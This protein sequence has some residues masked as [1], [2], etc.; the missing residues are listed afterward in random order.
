M[1]PLWACSHVEN[2]ER[3][4][5]A[6]PTVSGWVAWLDQKTSLVLSRWVTQASSTGLP[7]AF[8]CPA[9]LDRPGRL[10]GRSLHSSCLT[11]QARSTGLPEAFTR[12]VSLDRPSRLDF[13]YK[14]PEAFT[15]P[16]AFGRSTGLF[17]T[18]PLES[19]T[20]FG[21]LSLES[22]TPPTP[23]FGSLGSDFHRQCHRPT[24]LTHNLKE[25]NHRKP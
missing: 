11:G 18:L 19:L 12:P 1:Q 16:T 14:L 10:G 15:R 21:T 2:R 13:E 9:T 8:T 7:E 4:T 17:E 20:R 23:F 24:H 6:L 22:L 5:S 25:I 3:A